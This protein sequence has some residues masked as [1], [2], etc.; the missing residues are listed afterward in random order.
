MEIW[1]NKKAQDT[2]KAFQIGTIIES[3]SK[4]GGNSALAKVPL[5]ALQ[6][7]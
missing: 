2:S 5:P 3:D 4:R 7:W 6:P 1:K